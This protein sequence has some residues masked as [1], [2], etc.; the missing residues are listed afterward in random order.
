MMQRWLENFAEHVAIG[1]GIFIMGLFIALLIAI[2][3]ISYHTLRAAMNNPVKALRD[4]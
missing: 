3:T 2:L 4:D 1:P